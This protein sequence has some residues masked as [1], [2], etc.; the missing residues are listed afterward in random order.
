MHDAEYTALDGLGMAAAVAD[1][2]VSAR[3]LL[4]TALRRTKELNPKL[5]AVVRLLERQATARLA[6]NL[7]GPFAGVPFLLKDLGQD[8]AG[9]PTTAGSR[10]RSGTPAGQH[11]TVVQRWLDAGLV[12][13]GKTNTSE[14]GAKAVTEPELFGPARNPWDP[15]RTPGGSS[16]GAAAAV[17]AGIVPV[18]GASDGGGS[19]RIPAACCGVFG[20]K[21]GRGL[22]PA[23]P[24][25]GELING[26]ATHGVISRTVRDSA[27]MLD[28]L[29]GPDPLAPFA[30]AFPA[31]SYLGEVGKDPGR[32]RIGWQ[33]DSILGTAPAPEAT[34]AL[35]DAANLLSGLGHEVARVRTEVYG[36]DTIRDF[37]VPFLVQ[38]A[39]D[40]GE[41]GRGSRGRNG[42]ELDTL[43][44]AAA[45]RGIRAPELSRAIENWQRAR[46]RLAE[47]HREFDVLLT[48]AL[49]RAPLPIG[50]LRTPAAERAAARAF[51]A[52]GTVGLL[53]RL[54][55]LDRIARRQL[56]WAPYTQ[57]A[58]ITGRPAATV[59]L[60]RTGDGLPL[61][62][63]FIAP[64]GGEGLLLRLAAEL[65][66]ARPWDQPSVVL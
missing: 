20:L 6:E 54:G 56:S 32:L 45:G 46:I 8:F 55:V 2:Q 43:L 16:G 31:G 52:S 39:V 1:G 62:V 10:A 28:V 59:P 13:F 21:P 19:I 14:F 42:F 44:A 61:G 57:L 51:L 24:R 4:E 41:Q 5:N 36:P 11:A 34:A 26:S 49:A 38:I 47:V 63:Q 58:N 7:T 25:N 29:T 33:T 27:A 22:I 18:A 12:I 35:R 30:S 40:V 50:S 3:E 17:A 9:A 15:R 64:P 48:P 66:T 60:Y 65:E 37:L 53:T 23:G